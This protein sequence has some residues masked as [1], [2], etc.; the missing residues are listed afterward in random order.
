MFLVLKNK[1]KFEKKKKEYWSG[2]SFLSSEDLLDPGIKP[3]SP[4]LEDR[5][6]TMGSATKLTCRMM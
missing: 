2:L 6:L 5:F 4:A 1:N 3:T